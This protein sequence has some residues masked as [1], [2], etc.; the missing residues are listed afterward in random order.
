MG[1]TSKICGALREECGILGNQE[2]ERLIFILGSNRYP[3]GIIWKLTEILQKRKNGCPFLFGSKKEEELHDEAFAKMRMELVETNR[4]DE[5]T[6]ILQKF[7]GFYE[8]KYTKNLFKKLKEEKREW[9]EK[10]GKDE[11]SIRDILR[12]M[13]GCRLLILY[14]RRIHS[15]LFDEQSEAGKSAAS[16]LQKLNLKNEQELPSE[17]K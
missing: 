13:K 7:I 15:P 16:E 3:A 6:K 14:M 10:Y 1:R 8:G 17:I 2:D 9:Y 5:R 4:I 12:P 11:E